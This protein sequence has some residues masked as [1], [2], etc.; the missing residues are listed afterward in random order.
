MDAA[1]PAHVLVEAVLQAGVPG[2]LHAREHGPGVSA[3]GSHGVIYGRV[4]G[5]P[6]V[7]SGSFSAEDRWGLL[8]VLSP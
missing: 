4:V 5:G 3:A 6:T 7:G 2:G 8:L 1:L